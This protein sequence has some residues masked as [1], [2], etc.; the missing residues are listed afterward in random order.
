MFD[1]GNVI[2][3][4]DSDK[5]YRNLETLFLPDADRQLIEKTLEDYECG[6]ISTDIFIN[7]LI[8]QSRR[9]VQAI[10]IIEAWNSMLIGIPA[11]RLEMLRGLRNN[12]NVYFLSNTCELHIEWLNRHL[13]KIHGVAGFEKE[14]IHQA[15]YSHLIGSRKPSESIY[16]HVIEDSFLTPSATLYMDDVAINIE[17]GQKL[18]FETHLVEPGEEIAE[19]LKVEG[20]C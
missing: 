12:F 20:Y 4:I 18:G 6:K 16:R 7:N 1:L 10:D 5:A 11:Y 15:Y 2:V 14:F 3:D 8:K 17:M 19:Y 9:D 13:Q